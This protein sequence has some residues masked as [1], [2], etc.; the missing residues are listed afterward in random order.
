[1]TTKYEQQDKLFAIGRTP[2]PLLD[3]LPP[4]TFV[5]RS[6]EE[7]FFLEAT[8]SFVLPEKIY[9][10]IVKTGQRIIH[11]F[12]DRS[13][14]T[15]VLLTGEKGSGKTL[16]AKWLS[17]AAAA[18][19]MPTLL[20]NSPFS[21]D[22]FKVFMNS[23]EQPCVVVFD[24]FEKVYSNDSAS[25]TAKQDGLLTLFDGLFT[26]K[27]LYVL[28]SNDSY[29]VSDHMQNRPGRLYYLLKYGGLEL[30]F[31]E[32]YCKDKL[33]DQQWASKVVLLSSLFGKFNF[34]MLK[35]VVE[36]CNR[37]GESPF[38]AIK[39]LNIKPDMGGTG[40]FDVTFKLGTPKNGF[41]L[42]TTRFTGSPLATVGISWYYKNEGDDDDEFEETRFLQQ[43]LVAM[44]IMKGVYSFRN[45]NNDELL[46][47][48]IPAV[49]ENSYTRFLE[50]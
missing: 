23:I 15:G 34:D 18:E 1:M 50:L 20:I 38:E 2:S 46:L 9:G 13:G 29:R 25:G 26:T 48:R 39:M 31:I 8:D 47:T 33:Q 42:S 4:L 11:T 17:I 6:S 16:L 32:E 3:N 28:T 36:E 10:S 43:E 37:Y 35:A 30:D 5:V 7:G 40:I 27:K 45:K 22:S 24:E 44:D 12:H 19:G 14:G 49:P 41:K 21:G